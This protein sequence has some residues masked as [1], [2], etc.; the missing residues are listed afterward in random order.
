[1]RY[2]FSMSSRERKLELSQWR[3]L[4]FTLVTLVGHPDFVLIYQ[5]A[6]E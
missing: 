5:A 6:T 3:E 1:M 2:A 4:G